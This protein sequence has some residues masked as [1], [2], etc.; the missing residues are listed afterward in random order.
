V[1]LTIGVD[2]GGTKI[3]GGL[4]DS[5][6]DVVVQTRR[7]TPADNPPEYVARIAEVI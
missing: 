4:V 2:I 5:A 1:G 3:L 6:G 7:D